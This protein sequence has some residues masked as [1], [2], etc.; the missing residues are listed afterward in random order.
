VK[1]ITELNRKSAELIE[2]V[3]IEDGIIVWPSGGVYGL[4]CNA[5]SKKAVNKVYELKNRSYEKPLSIIVS[6]SSVYKFGKINKLSEKII[7]KF[8]PDFIGIIVDK[9]NLIQDFVTSNKKKVGLVCSSQINI[10]LA[11]SVSVPLASTSANL[12]GQKEISEFETAYNKFKDKAE[13]I[14]K[15]SENKSCLNTI[16]DIVNENK[17]KVLR[18]GKYSENEL[19]D[20]LL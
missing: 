3:I 11:D 12:S 17:F 19:R 18:I 6:P 14:I 2:K 13:L 7:K 4:A 20:M 10:F 8:W 5:L 15:Y 1:I 9:N 16:I